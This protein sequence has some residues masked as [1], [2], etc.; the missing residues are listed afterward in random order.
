MKKLF[1]LLAAAALLAALL[2]AC[3]G[4]VT[5]AQLKNYNAGVKAYEA[6][7]FETAKAYFQAAEGYGNAPSYISAIEE[8]ERIYKDALSLFN[9]HDYPAARNSFSAISQF[10]N[11][12]EYVDFIDRLENRYNEGL[13][14]FEKEDY[15][16]AHQRFIQAMGYADSDAYVTRIAGLENSYQLALGFIAEGSYIKAMQELEKIGVD[17]KDTAELM[18]RVY[19][20]IRQ[21]GV[22]ASI[23]RDLFN[24]SFEKTGEVVS[25]DYAEVNDLSFVWRA[26][27]GLIIM[28]N[29]DY[30]GYVQ[31]IS[32]WI[33]RKLLKELGSE[34]TDRMFAHCVD[35]LANGEASFDEILA[36]IDLYYEGSRS[37]GGYG[38]LLDEDGSGAEVLTADHNG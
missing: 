25:I 38:F 16:T 28:G 19:A 17:Y 32:F 20:L 6:N 22:T 27:N 37:C 14:A 30:E 21:K 1:R 23:Y 31:S 12:A 35:S 3:A 11:A 5:N 24:E 36:D 10:G 18:D 13:E 33:E 26:S 8:Y 4:C 2:G 15:V 34:G 29:T 9:A 7:D